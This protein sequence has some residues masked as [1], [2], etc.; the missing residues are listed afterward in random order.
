MKKRGLAR[1]FTLIEL[2][3]VIGIIA[4]LAAILFPVFAQVRG[5]AR[6]TV[7]V[8]NMRQLGMAIA[9]YSQ[10]Y[11]DLYP[12]GIDAS[13][14]YTPI[15]A[16]QGDA[17]NQ[18]KGLKDPY[19]MLYYILKPYTKSDD[20]WRCPSDTG[21]DD[22]DMN[23]YN[24]QPTPLKARPTSY[25][26]FHSSYLYRTELALKHKPYSAILSYDP[27]PPY[28]EHGPG[29]INVLMDGNGSWHGGGIFQQKRY[30]VLL[31][32][33]HVKNENI[34]QFNATWNLRLEPGGSHY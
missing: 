11:D 10:D 7:C 2:L 19:N 12:Y 13:D 8:A 22:L 3:V 30:N 18:L 14:Y 16:Q 24:G 29:D 6:E 5:K 27:F 1:G 26:A 17:Y 9:M 21:Y 25:Q 4:V 32:D 15:W 34:D 31:G 20:I 23:T 28:A 33:G